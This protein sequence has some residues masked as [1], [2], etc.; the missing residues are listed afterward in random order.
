[1]TVDVVWLWVVAKCDR[2]WDLPFNNYNYSYIDHALSNGYSTLSYDRL[3]IGQSSHGDPKNEIQASLEVA[4]LAEM[5]RMVRKGSFPGIHQKPEKVV[6]VG[7]SFGSG[8]TYALSAM[9]PDLSDAIVLTGFSL[10][11]SFMP[12][13]L[14]GANFQQAHGQ[15]EGEGDYPPGYLV[16]SN[17]NAN[18]YLFFHAPNFD[19]DMLVFAEQ[20]KKPVTVGELMT[21][22][23]VP[24]QS[25]FTGPVLIITGSND[26]PFCG[27]DCLNTG[28]G[29]AA[30][31]PA[32]GKVAF[33]ESKAFEA[34][35][36]PETGHGL[37]RHYNATGAYEYIAGFLGGNGIA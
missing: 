21:S 8:Q 13:F 33:P 10:N 22:G 23:S 26:L 11:S 32:Q 7:H 28:G 4:S 9:Y 16:S 36:Q 29:V 2:Y 5:T 30:S 31:I 15:I 37:N 34:Y 12:F 25:G 20:S 24:M 1:M 19:P 14:T 35:V 27:G 3:G 6:H 18:H 17:I